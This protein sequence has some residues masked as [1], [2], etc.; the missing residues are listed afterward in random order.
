MIL[1]APTLENLHRLGGSD[2][3]PKAHA[4]RV[5]CDEFDSK[6]C[7]TDEGSLAPFSGFRFFGQLADSY[8]RD[9]S[10]P[11]RLMLFRFGLV[12]SLD[13]WADVGPHFRAHTFIGFV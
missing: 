10:C 7:C 13:V 12:E 9:I 8:D 6:A 1:P 3:V 5:D 4:N 2:Y 11:R